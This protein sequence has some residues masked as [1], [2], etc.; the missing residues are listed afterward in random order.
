MNDINTYLNEFLEKHPTKHIAVGFSGGVDSIVLLNALVNLKNQHQF[1]LSAI[2]INHNLQSVS[3][4]WEEFCKSFAQSKNVPL[5]STL[6]TDKPPKG[7]S[8]EAWA[9]E[10]RYQFFDKIMKDIKAE[11][12]YL[13][14]HQNDQAETFLLN[15]MRGSGINGLSAMPQV[16]QRNQYY[17][18]RPLLH[19]TKEPI[20][21]YAKDKNL[22]WV[23]DSTNLDTK[24]DRNYVRH[25]V[26]PSL[27][28]RFS[29]V[30]HIAQSSLYCQEVAQLLEKYLENDL[31]LITN[32]TNQIDYLNLLQY[33][34]IKQTYL[35][36]LWLKKS[37]IKPPSRRKMAEF[38]KSIKNAENNWEFHWEQ[39][40]IIL[41]DNLLQCY[42]ISSEIPD[43][44]K[45][46]WTDRDKLLSLFSYHISKT[47]LAYLGLDIDQIDFNQ[48]TLRAR[49]PK[50]RCQPL[51]RN[52]SNTLKVIF[53]EKQIPKWLR[54][55]TPIVE[56]KDKII[57]VGKLF[58]CI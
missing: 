4:K 38:I 27:S 25:H 14:H 30:K 10:K 45:C 22:S 24:F 56:Y 55:R 9:R 42:P 31:M 54:K 46:K 17:I 15:L 18:A 48:V 8:I 11:Y 57:A 26:L 58:T 39:H 35:I 21:T 53:Q 1:S 2:H 50:D 37:Q 12:L 34:E 43:D 29:A 36:R 3:K 28:E 47:D 13:A 23:E 16:R 20:K 6:I 44:F 5:Y 51:D 52:K 7:E 41:Y 32:E 49:K 33:D 40:V 19:I